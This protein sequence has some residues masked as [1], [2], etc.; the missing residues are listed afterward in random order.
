MTTSLEEA[1]A[2]RREAIQPPPGAPERPTTATRESPAVAK[3]TPPDRIFY[4]RTLMVISAALMPAS[5]AQSDRDNALKLARDIARALCGGGFPKGYKTY[6]NMRTMDLILLQEE[7]LDAERPGTRSALSEGVKAQ[8]RAHLKKVAEGE[9]VPTKAELEQINDADLNDFANLSD[10]V[11][12]H[13]ADAI[14]IRLGARQDITGARQDDAFNCVVDE[15]EKAAALAGE[16]ELPIAQP[17][18][19]DPIGPEH[20][21]YPASSAVEFVEAAAEAASEAGE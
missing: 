8:K 10:L 14:A 12:S 9:V 5:I 19:E 2:K 17:S 20:F 11:R 6:R 13:A 3:W 7:L 1:R 4:H 18:D 21:P 16:L 15:L